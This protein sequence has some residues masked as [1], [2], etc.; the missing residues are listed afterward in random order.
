MIL[1][2]SRTMFE[3]L[4]CWSPL[5]E[6]GGPDNSHVAHLCTTVDTTVGCCWT[7][8]LAAQSGFRANRGSGTV[9]PAR[10]L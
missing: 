10:G 9:V 6:Y 4:V 7:T 3:R 1:R 5:S 8:G 2:N